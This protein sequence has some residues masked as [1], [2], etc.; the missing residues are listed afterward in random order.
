VFQRLGNRN[1][2]MIR[3]NYPATK[4]QSK[5]ANVESK[6]F[7]HEFIPKPRDPELRSEIDHHELQEFPF[8]TKVIYYCPLPY[9]RIRFRE[10]LS[11]SE[12]QLAIDP[13]SKLILQV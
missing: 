9:F 11:G 4:K 8:L 12:C 2:R 6:N 5:E 1:S 13:K 10:L 3:S 7:K